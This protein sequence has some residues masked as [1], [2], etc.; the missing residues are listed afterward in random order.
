MSIFD[1]LITSKLRVRI[2]MRLFLHPDQQSYI[3][4]LAGELGASPSQIKEE[5]TNLDAAGLLQSVKR[6]R[7]INYSANQQHPLYPELHSMVKKALGMDRI[8]DSIVER[9]GNLEMAL[10]VDDYAM[11]K[12]TGLIDLI[13]IGR[14]NQANLRDLVGKTEKYIHRKIRVMTLSDA[15]FRNSSHLFEQRARLV[16]WKA[17]S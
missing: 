5:L 6:G 10:L 9:L 15:E 7:M 16:I 2:L 13:L 12:D 11:G 4:E 1:G 8:I 3:R 17:H 14:I